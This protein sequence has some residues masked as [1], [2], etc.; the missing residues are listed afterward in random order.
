MNTF[1]L[2]VST[3]DGNVFE[4]KAEALFVRGTEGD[5]AVLADHAPLLTAVQDCT[6]RILTEASDEITA[7]ILGGLLSV[8]E[9][10]AT[11]LLTTS[12]VTND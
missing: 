4:G 8:T 10:G 6:C 2:V 11:I 1:D 5:L 7:Q 3:P 9:G 12:F